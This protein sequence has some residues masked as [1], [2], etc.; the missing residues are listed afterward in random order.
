MLSKPYSS[1]GVL[2]LSSLSGSTGLQLCYFLTQPQWLRGGLGTDPEDGVHIN[3]YEGKLPTI[4]KQ[5]RG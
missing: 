1:L 2:S 3:V 5:G 4:L